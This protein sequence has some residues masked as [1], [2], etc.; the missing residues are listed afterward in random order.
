VGPRRRGRLTTAGARVLTVGYGGRSP[1]DFVALLKA[2]G[3][4]TVADVRLK[5]Q[6]AMMGAYAKA[7]TADKG[8]EKL[9][10]DAGIGYA[11]LQDLGNPYMGDDDW[12]DCYRELM[13]E[14][15][16]E[17]TAPLLTLEGPVCLLCAEKRPDDCHRRLVAEWLAERGW[18]V[19]HLV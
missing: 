14:S 3:V 18:Q 7:K 11:W 17:R 10:G 5:P 4:R 12:A 13:A 19:V 2:N 16:E 8:I 6:K 9:L 1:S 15:G